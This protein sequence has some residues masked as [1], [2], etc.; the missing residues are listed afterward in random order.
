MWTVDEQVAL[1]ASFKL[2]AQRSDMGAVWSKD[3]LWDT[4]KEDFVQRIP[5]SLKPCDLKGRWSERTA[6]SM[7]TQ[8]ERKI[9]PD[10]QHFAHFFKVVSDKK[11]L[12]GRQT[13][14]DLVRA[15]AGLFSGVSAYQAVRQDACSDDERERQ[16]GAGGAD[17]SRGDV[18]VHPHVARAERDGQVQRGGGRQ[19]RRRRP[20]SRHSWSAGR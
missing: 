5:K 13:E 19:Q 6:G 2:V 14:E 4:I 12:T 16:G 18:R 17:R 15:A 11:Q 8:F 20:L 9:A 10:V 7:Q 3:G 1:C